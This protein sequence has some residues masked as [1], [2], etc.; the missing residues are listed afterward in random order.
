[1]AER[2]ARVSVL[3]H[4]H[5][6]DGR[7]LGA[8]REALPGVD[9]RLWPDERGDPATITDAVAW[10]P[11]ADFFD[12]LHALERVHALA[13]G[14]DNLLDHPGLPATAS[15]IRL[16]DAGMGELM[17]EYVLLGVLHAHRGLPRLAA[18]QRAGRWAAE[19]RT[20]PAARF[21]VGILGAGVLGA[22]VARR[23][24]ANGYPVG[25]WSR[26]AKRLP[27]GV[28][29]HV[30]RDGLHEC[31]RGARVLVCLLPLTGQTR[32]ILDAALFARLPEGAYLINVA[33]GEHLVEADLLA[34]LDGGRLDGAL[35]DVF[36]EEPLPA[37]HPFWT[38]PRI[39]V[40]PHLAAPSPLRESAAQVAANLAAVARGERPSGTV[41]RARGY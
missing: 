38:H 35:L 19:T 14:V 2:R 20:P 33:R 39:T 26:T 15:V 34:A 41:D 8:L 3:F 5:G 31:L 37:G 21:G 36:R 32:D 22:T 17:A 24:V 27:P 29:G 4:C 28:V 40:T 25:C 18:A 16:E 6:D 7:M 30:G 11:P 12:G 23:L 1:M 13:A 10:L 9:V